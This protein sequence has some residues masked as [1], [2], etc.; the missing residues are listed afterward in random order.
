MLC[1]AQA[2]PKLTESLR[3]SPVENRWIVE[4][5]KHR[6]KRTKGSLLIPSYGE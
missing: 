5:L 1:K 3:N 4:F 2:P 6:R